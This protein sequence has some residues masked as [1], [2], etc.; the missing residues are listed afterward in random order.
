MGRDL[1]GLAT[2]ILT[3]RPG[4]ASNL[5][6]A[7]QEETLPHFKVATYFTGW[8]EERSRHGIDVATWLGR[9]RGRD[10]EMKLRPSLGLCKGKEVATRHAVSATNRV[11]AHDQPIMRTAGRTTWALRAQCVLDL[12]SGCTH[13]APNPVLTQCT[14]YSHCLDHCS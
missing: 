3:S 10:L 2:R 6:L 8:A 11:C 9:P 7:S 5:F 12:G 14:I 4:W 13:C 1:A